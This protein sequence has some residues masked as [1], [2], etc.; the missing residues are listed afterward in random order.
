V[1]APLPC[2]DGGFRCV[3]AD[4]PWRFRSNSVARPGRN[5]ARH[6]ACLT[7]SG[8][9]TLPLADVVARDAWLFLWT[10]GPFIAQGAHVGVMKAWGFSPSGVAFVWA[11][12]N[13]NAPELFFNRDDFFFGQGLTTRHNAEY[14]ILGRRGNPKRLAADVREIIAAPRRRHSEKPVEAFARIE[15]FCDGPRLEL[16]ARQRRAGWQAWGDEILNPSE[17]KV[18]RKDEP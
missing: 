15:R 12:L 5:A 7:P 8:I 1:F 17:P 4:P 9:A 16:F 3:A 18:E 14:C 10:T 11:K 6:Y 2:V 13:R